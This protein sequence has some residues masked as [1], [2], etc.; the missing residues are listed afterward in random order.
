MDIADRLRLDV[1]VAQAGM[2]GGLAGA[3]LAAAVAEAGGLGTLGIATPR[4]LRASIDE[5]RERTPG[6]AVAVN[7]LLHFVHRGHITACVDAG[8]DAVVLAFG[9]KRGLVRHLRDAGI[10]VFVMVGTPGQ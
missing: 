9:E 2:G 8:V 5:V 6:R 7:L 4:R 3:A 10:F 1:P